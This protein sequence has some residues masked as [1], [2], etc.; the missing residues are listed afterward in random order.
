VFLCFLIF[1]KTNQ[2]A[3]R[4]FGLLEQ[5]A[6]VYVCGH[7]RMGQGVNEAL[8]KIVL[9]ALKDETAATKY[10]DNLFETSRLKT[11]VFA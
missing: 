8:R 4:L 7:T 2:K 1:F 9:L 11:D 10:I 5:G 6:C 3:E